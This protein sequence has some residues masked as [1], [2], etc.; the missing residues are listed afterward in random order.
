[1]KIHWTKSKL[2]GSRV[3]QWM[4]GEDCSHL[5]LCFGEGPYAVVIESTLF[6][7]VRPTWNATFEKHH[8][9]VHT[10]D[11]PVDA[12]VEQEMYQ[13]IIDRVGG[14]AYDWKAVLF[15]GVKIALSKIGITMPRNQWADR[16]SIYCVEVLSAIREYLEIMGADLS[17]L[18]KQMMS[19]H[20]AYIAL[21]KI[22]TAQ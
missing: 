10:L 9:I 3:I 18:D 1:M 16:G 22:D 2:V 19:P 17:L 8:T 7:G 5:S 20:D 15:W 21:A 14:K 11:L 12:G 6:T 13:A 4:L